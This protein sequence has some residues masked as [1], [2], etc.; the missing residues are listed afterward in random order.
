MFA[1]KFKK[2]FSL[3]YCVGNTALHLAVMLGHKGWNIHKNVGTA[4]YLILNL[5]PFRVYTFVVSP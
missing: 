3:L 1:L 2:C 5:F 4:L